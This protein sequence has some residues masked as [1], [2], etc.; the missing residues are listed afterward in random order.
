MV[1]ALT[2]TLLLA[3]GGF[4]YW[5]VQKT[6]PESSTAAEFF[7]GESRQGKPPALWL[8]IASAAI[9][10]IFA[11][12]IDNAA[13]LAQSFG[14]TGG[15]GYAIYYLSFFTAAVGIYYI[16]VRGGYHSLP[17]FLVH[18]YGAVCAKLFLIAIAIRL[19]NLDAGG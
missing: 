8:L 7:Q 2:W 11:K 4:I 6:T 15:I 12:S 17:E 10:W 5:I 18:K 19:F 3:Y 9:S 16:R 1:S 14:V 13:S